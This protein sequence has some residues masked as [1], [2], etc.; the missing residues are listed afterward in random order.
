M[1]VGLNVS[2]TLATTAEKPSTSSSQESSFA[3]VLGSQRPSVP[4]WVACESGRVAVQ[5]DPQG[6]ILKARYFDEAGRA[7]RSSIF[8]APEILKACEE[9]AIPH[10]DLTSLGQALDRYGIGFR[11][12]ELHKGTGSDH[13][14]DL[15]DLARGGL[16]SAYDWRSDPHAASRGPGALEALADYQAL[17]ARTQRQLNA[18]VT[19]ER[20]VRADL[21]QSYIGAIG[22]TR[23]FVVST[24]SFAAQYRTASEAQVAAATYGTARSMQL[25]DGALMAALVDQQAPSQADPISFDI[26]AQGQS[27]QTLQKAQTSQALDALPPAAMMKVGQPL[28]NTLEASAPDA[29]ADAAQD[30]L[31]FGSGF[32]QPD[33]SRAAQSSSLLLLDVASNTVNLALQQVQFQRKLA[34]DLLGEDQAN[35][36][37]KS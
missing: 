3:A 4:E 7:L 2:K 27:A 9:F 21:M 26:D 8:T 6:N 33:A 20:G 12:Y 1:E 14:V 18:E 23:P 37:A 15:D 25:S 16:G 24:G 28:G 19:T 5:T 17:S 13:G 35:Q 31:A 22:E 10:D 36:N 30:P 34:Q 11:P 32:T 29:R